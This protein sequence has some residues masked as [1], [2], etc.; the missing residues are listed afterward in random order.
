MRYDD[1]ELPNNTLFSKS[2]KDHTLRFW[3]LRDKFEFKVII[4]GIHKDIKFYN[5]KEG[6]Y[7]K[8]MKVHSNIDKDLFL[9]EEDE[10]T[11]FTASQDES[12]KM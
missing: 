3:N 11:L 12:I 1:L 2:Q 10:D 5:L 9:Q 6:K 8:K 7:K 4:V